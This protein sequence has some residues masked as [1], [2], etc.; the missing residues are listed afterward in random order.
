M[1]VFEWFS[2]FWLLPVFWTYRCRPMLKVRNRRL[3]LTHKNLLFTSSWFTMIRWKETC[4]WR[5]WVVEMLSITMLRR[6]IT[7]DIIRAIIVERIMLL[8]IF[9]RRFLLNPLSFLFHF[10]FELFHLLADSL[11]HPSL[12]HS[13][14]SDLNI[15]R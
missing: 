5:I 10:Y 2:H 1:Q 13:L 4:V 7:L 14:Y 11:S 9:H 3:V 15:N 8:L 12:N 6:V